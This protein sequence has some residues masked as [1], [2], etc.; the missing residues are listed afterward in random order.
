ML[1]QVTEGPPSSGTA[2]GAAKATPYDPRQQRLGVVLIS[3][4]SPSPEW[5]ASQIGLRDEVEKQLKTMD[6]YGVI[7][8]V[9]WAWLEFVPEMD[10]KQTLDDLE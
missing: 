7:K 9:R 8:T 10:I 6:K 3:H 4:G 1:K 5:N 2:S